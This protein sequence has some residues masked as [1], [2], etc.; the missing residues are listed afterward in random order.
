MT[1]GATGAVAVPE[2]PAVAPWCRVVSDRGRVLLEHGGTVVTFEGA[3]ATTLLPELLPLLDGTR[4]VDELEE[5]MGRPV[6]PAVSRALAL[7]AEYH[8]LV[9][10][11]TE[12]GTEDAL[13]AAASFAAAVTRRTTPAAA[14]EALVS[15]S[16]AVLGSG[17]QA[18]EIGRQL[19]EAGI[20]VESLS[21][22]GELDG[23]SFPVAAPAPHELDGL[24][25]VN[26]RLVRERRAWLQVL[27]HDG[28]HLVVGPLFLPRSSA[29]RECYRLR[30]AACSGY[31]DDFDVVERAPTRAPVP[32]PIRSIAAGL[33]ALLAIR[34]LT[35]ADPTLPGRFYALETGSALRLS[36]H[37][38][39]RVPR[40]PVCAEW[41]GAVPLPWF[42]EAP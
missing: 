7:L 21:L 17:A 3:G 4:T 11:P 40:C 29:C 1:E 18:A 5:V 16:V 36:S 14:R 34:W 35:S 25:T 32:A 38:V 30:R 12:P 41:G 31:T 26:R 23:P 8:L 33:A 13:T 9:E 27:P 24:E 19:G 28:R 20:D 37:H 22:D 42:K 15:S 2:R 39:L 6:A 10:G